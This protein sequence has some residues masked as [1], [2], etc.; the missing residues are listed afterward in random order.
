MK[1]KT[2]ARVMLGMAAASPLL[3]YAQDNRGALEEIIVTAQKREEAIQDVPVAISAFSADNLESQG[4]HSLLDLQGGKVPSLAVMSFAGRPGL[5]TMSIRGVSEA[6]AT[7]LAIERPLALYVDGVYMSRTNMQDTELL[8]LERIEV[9][10]GPQGTLFGRNAEGGAVSIITQKP[11]GEFGIRQELEA[12]TLDDNRAKTILDLPAVGGLSSRLVYVKHH[13]AGWTGNPDPQTEDFGY[14]DKDGYRL[15]LQYQGVDDVLVDYAYDNS[16][17]DYN[18]SYYTMYG[19]GSVYNSTFGVVIPNPNPRAIDD[20]RQ[21]Q[22]WVG[23]RYP[24]SSNDSSGHT[25][26]IEWFINDTLTFKSISGY[27]EFT[28]ASFANDSGSQAVQPAGGGAFLA[29]ITAS[30]LTEADQWSQEFQLIGE[31][32]TI[33]WQVGVLYFHEDGYYQDYTAFTLRYPTLASAPVP[34]ALDTPI[35]RTLNVDTDSYGAYAQATWT[36]EILDSRLHLT[37]GA[38]YSNDDKFVER[39]FP[40]GLT[41]NPK[42][43]RFDPAVTVAYDFLDELSGYLRWGTAYRGGGAAMR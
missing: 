36:P 2:L 14:S 21:E 27:R 40:D 6:D 12:S 16:Q 20:G 13:N 32:D 7:Q 15:A 35:A 29:G 34:F 25:L 18:T 23:T 43:S 30:S 10:R 9:L 28:E 24:M 8:T 3:G 19:K 22:A 33:D 37:A 39:N 17:V 5:L 26:N 31:T 1:M 38:H 4:V 11:R 42:E 41:T